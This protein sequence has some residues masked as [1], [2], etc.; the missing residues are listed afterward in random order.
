VGFDK[1]KFLARFVSEA[2]EHI[3]SLR[4]GLLA[5]EKHPDDTDS[6]N[7]VFRM[8]HTIK[9][10]S[11]MMKLTPISSVAHKLEDVMDA[12]RQGKIRP[13]QDLSDLLFKGVAEI[14]RMLDETSAGKEITE[15][16]TE[17]CEKLEAAAKGESDLEEIAPQAT[18]PPPIP[19]IP[20][21]DVTEHPPA[22]APSSPSSLETIRLRSDKLDELIKLMGEIISGHSRSKQ[23]LS[24]IKKIERLVKRHAELI[25]DVEQP[26]KEEILQTAKSLYLAM[27]KLAADFKEDVNIQ[28]LLS[29]ELQDKSLK[30]RMIPLSTIFDAFRMAVRDFSKSSDK[31]IDFVI[32]GGETEL[33]KKIIEKIGDSLIH[34]IRNC[35]DHGIE[36]P[37][38][39]LKIGKPAVGKIVLSAGYEGGNVVIELSDD[40]AGIPISKL[41]EKALKKKLLDETAIAE[42]ADTDI[43]NMIFMPG[44]SSSDIITD[45]SGR[46]VGMDVVRKNIIEDLKGAIRITTKDG[47]GTSFYIRL[48]L[49]MA[50]IHVLFVRVSETTFAV[51]AHFISE[52]VRVPEDNLI[53][54][55]DKKALRLREQII[56]ILSLKDMLKL[57]YPTRSGSDNNLLILI[58]ALGNE[59][60]GMMIDELLS[61][62]D[63]VIKS[64]PALMK[65]IQTVSG[66]V[67][68]GKNE[69]FNV[70]HIP[71]IIETAKESNARI[72][73]QSETTEETEKQIRILIADDS[74]TTREIEKSI[75]ESY[76]YSVDIAG[77]G[78]EGLEMAKKINY[79]LIITD[80][81][82]P[83]L[84][85]F[86]L[87]RQ[88]RN[89]E[90][91][92][93]TPIILVTSLDKEEDKKRGIEAGA[94]AYIVKGAFD[95][96]ALLD[97]VQHLTG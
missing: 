84:D 14:E 85:G 43:I 73:I 26:E 77:D 86:S 45:V 7:S 64:L 91:Y 56:P 28:G 40:G 8:A 51:P 88:L 6:L 93:H 74:V 68:S 53:Q 1:A 72:K 67:I 65:T 12:L 30:M 35:V 41:K 92:A 13:G 70:L 9:G 96:S 59:K 81:E 66:V 15:I 94:N 20:Q 87:I 38:E 57:S 83:R 90:G 89:E 19:V 76:G 24:D 69:L 44:F 32:H 46:G 71:K 55:M 95:Q 17:F 48:P 39:R 36:M 31:K 4:E 52:I 49:T 61:E 18:E 54:V 80:A 50:I 97:S 34:L 27:K 79:D 3:I 58:G 29:G 5:L 10:A 47:E 2:R 62:E 60:I 82:M 16:P 22:S 42:I 63:V 21:P 75:L 37:E 11:K 23:R 25:S 33:D 78:M